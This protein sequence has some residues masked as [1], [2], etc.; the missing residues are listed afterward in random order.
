MLTCNA[1]KK[2]LRGDIEV[3]VLEHRTKETFKTNHNIK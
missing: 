3:K 1:L 2:K